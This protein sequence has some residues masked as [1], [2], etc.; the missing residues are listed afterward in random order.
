MLAETTG[1]HEA[2]DLYR[3]STQLGF[4][5]EGALGYA[6]MV[7]STILNIQDKAD[8]QYIYSIKNMNAVV[9]ACDAV[10]WYT[11]KLVILTQFV[12]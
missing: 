2:M 8:K 3:H 1:H 9:I 5:P 6:S 4:H 10:T 11:G 7:L 12:K